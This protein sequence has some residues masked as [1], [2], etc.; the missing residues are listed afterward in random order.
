MAFLVGG[1]AGALLMNIVFTW[2]LIVL[3]SLGGAALICESFHAAPQIISAVFTVLA[4]LGVPFQSGL[5]PA[6]ARGASS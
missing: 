3:S 5:A 1:L 6:Q 4:I 2:T